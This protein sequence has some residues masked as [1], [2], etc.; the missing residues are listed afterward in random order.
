MKVKLDIPCPNPT[1][2]DRTSKTWHHA[3]CG[4]AIWMDDEGFLE[5]EKKDAR[6]FIKHWSFAC[7]KHPGNYYQPN[8]T[9]LSYAL[10]LAVMASGSNRDTM[11]WLVNLSAKI[12]NDWERM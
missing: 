9:D 4:G 12:M 1:C 7:S 3:S 5:C 6:Y 8:A 10:G 2:T 11:K